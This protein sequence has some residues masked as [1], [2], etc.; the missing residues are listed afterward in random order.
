MELIK[1]MKS[2][3]KSYDLDSAR[4]ELSDMH[5]EAMVLGAMYNA[6]TNGG[7]MEPQTPHASTARSNAVGKRPSV[8]QTAAEMAQFKVL[9]FINVST[10]ISK[11]PENY[12]C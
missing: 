9:I 6:A 8:A 11:S 10:S 3:W 5:F 7:T 4:S 12:F 1:T 2:S